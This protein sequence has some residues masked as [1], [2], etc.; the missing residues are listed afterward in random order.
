MCGIG[1]PSVSIEPC[2]VCVHLHSVLG[3]SEGERH[4]VYTF[5]HVHVHV[6]TIYELLLLYVIGHQIVCIII[7]N[8]KTQVW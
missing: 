8:V 4:V 6:C 5:V 3:E 7:C 2:L 1:H